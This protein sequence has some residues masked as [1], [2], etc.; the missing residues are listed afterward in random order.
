MSDQGLEQLKAVL[1][2]NIKALRKQRGLAQE[3]LGLDSGVDRT[4][5]SKIERELANPSLEILHKLA[6]TLGVPVSTLISEQKTKKVGS[7]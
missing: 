5:V 2:A 4:L 6:S 3:K 1:S 7:K